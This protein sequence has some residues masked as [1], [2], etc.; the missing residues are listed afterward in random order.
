MDNFQMNP[1]MKEPST[2]SDLVARPTERPIYKLSPELLSN[3]FIE[4]AA[5]ELPP[6]MQGSL[7]SVHLKWIAVTHVCRYW[8][9]VA[10][11][12]T[13]L[14]RTLFFFNPEVTKEMIRRAKGSNLEVQI[15]GPIPQRLLAAVG[16]AFRMVIPEL[17]HTSTLHLKLHKNILQPLCDGFVSAAPNLECLTLCSSNDYDKLRVQ[18]TIFAPNMPAL[19]SLEL[20]YCTLMTSSPPSSTSD[21]HL[22]HIPSTISQIVSYL[23]RMPM[24]HTLI[25]GEVLPEELSADIEYPK[26]DLPELSKL[27]VIGSIT[28]CINFLKHLVFP[29]TTVTTI[30]CKRLSRNANYHGLF[31][32]FCSAIG[33]GEVDF[34]VQ[35]LKIDRVR[36]TPQLTSFHLKYTLT[37]RHSSL[38]TIVTFSFDFYGDR[39]VGGYPEIIED[40]L[41]TASRAI[42]PTDVHDLV[43][44]SDHSD[45]IS[46]VRHHLPNILNIRIFQ[47][48]SRKFIIAL[49]DRDSPML[50]RLR[51]LE[52]VNVFFSDQDVLFLLNCLESR[53]H[54]GLPIKTIH[55]SEC[56]QIFEAEVTRMKEFVQFVDWDGHEEDVENYWIDE[57]NDGVW[58]SGMDDD[59]DWGDD[60]YFDE[61]GDD[62][63]DDNVDDEDDEDDNV[64][65]DDDEDNDW[66]EDYSNTF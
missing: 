37:H 24:L 21:P 28:S 17:Y 57:E 22:V 38:P 54:A 43:V 59:A 47:I 65:Y 41:C 7:Y 18:D 25:L 52:F 2:A 6:S 9:S 15:E 30:H 48:Y 12:C 36:V 34:A 14:W 29:P 16:E 32:A 63:D 55:L 64:D 5:L 39:R 44:F 8:R 35:A 51:R 40:V 4:C 23:R 53:F 13:T 56:I 10:L 49:G 27:T 50:P 42:S 3:I 33:N 31:H 1:Y 19:R 26:L 11:G 58:D 45:W 61:D 62:E 60:H 66:D 20:E 46:G